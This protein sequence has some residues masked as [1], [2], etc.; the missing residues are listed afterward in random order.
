V[1]L[2][3]WINGRGARQADAIPPEQLAEFGT[4]LLF[5]LRPA[6]KGKVR[7]LTSYSWGRNPYVRGNKHEWR[8]GQMPTLRAA[9]EQKT[10]PIHFAGE[11]FRV[12]EP[13]ME[14]AAESGERAALRILG[15]V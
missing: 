13:G 15:V 1:Y 11:H 6:A 14:S 2:D 5:K 12:G 9:I 10:A 4:D 8:P 3:A 7:F